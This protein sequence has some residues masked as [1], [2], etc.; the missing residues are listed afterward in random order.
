M[1]IH[2]VTMPSF[3][4]QYASNLF[5]DLHKQ[6]YDTLV[7]PVTSTL[8]LLGNIGKP[9]DQKT[10]HFL[11]YCSR[12]W[13]SVLLISGP[14]ELMK[15]PT[16]TQG[17]DAIKALSKE[18]PNVRYLD[19]KEEVFHSDNTILLGL[20]PEI[21]KYYR[22]DDVVTLLRTVFW[23]MTHPMSNILF[24]TSTPTEKQKN[25]IPIKGSRLESPSIVWLVG[26]STKNT[27]SI[28]SRGRQFFA[29]NSCFEDSRLQK[30]RS[31]SPS[32]FVEFVD[33]DSGM[34][35]QLPNKSLQLA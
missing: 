27:L 5:V 1:Y 7:K 29:T 26:D 28:D 2:T 24:L 4:L 12:N 35:L 15:Y 8:A 16:Y 25:L 3:R 13:D 14:H 32:A 33:R 9:H 11:N 20:S 31:Y 34:S 18:F 30:R 22:S 17:F 19:S 10:Y 23:T 6:K 21:S